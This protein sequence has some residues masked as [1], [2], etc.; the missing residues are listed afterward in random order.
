MRF[1]IPDFHI[2]RQP[3]E[4]TCGPTCLQSVLSYYGD[5]TPLSEVINSIPDLEAGGT[6]SV[7]LANYALKKGFKATT[8]TYNLQV[9]DPSW[10]KG[11]VDIAD[12]L[13]QQAKFKTKAKLRTATE[14]YLSYLE[15]GGKILFEDMSP[16]LIRKILTSGKPII[17]GLSSTYLYNSKREYG[18][19]C[20][21][22]DIRGL[23]S[24]HFVVIYG[25]DSKRRKVY[26]ADPLLPN[27]IN[28]SQLYSVSMSHLICSILLGVLTYDAKL[29]IIEPSGER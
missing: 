12:K 17:C 29:L 5:Q 2:S 16:F 25:Y 7:M 26:I 20:D 24:G 18:D 1:R 8:Y 3:D 15:L 23:P 19:N 6:L 21:Y 22:D 4:T 13:R 28:N 10:F 9:F 27:P 11:N 14:H